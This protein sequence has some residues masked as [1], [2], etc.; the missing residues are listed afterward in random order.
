[1]RKFDS[2]ENVFVSQR[3]KNLTSFSTVRRVSLEKTSGNTTNVLK[4]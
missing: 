2:H 1:M 4:K 3:A